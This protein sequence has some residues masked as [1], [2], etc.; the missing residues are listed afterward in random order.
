MGADELCP[1]NLI[2]SACI[3]NHLCPSSL[4][5]LARVNNYLCSNLIALARSNNHNGKLQDFV[6]FLIDVAIH[7]TPPR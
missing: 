3:N 5:A 7:A 4:I 1:S 6:D 2:A